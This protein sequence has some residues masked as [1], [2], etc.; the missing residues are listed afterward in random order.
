MSLNINQSTRIVVLKEG[1]A[2]PVSSNDPID[3][4]DVPKEGYICV[5]GRVL[6]ADRTKSIEK[7]APVPSMW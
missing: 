7:M 2:T 6:P 5:V 3:I 1:V 4:N